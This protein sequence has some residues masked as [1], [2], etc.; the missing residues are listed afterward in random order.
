MS[1]KLV[2]IAVLISVGVSAAFGQPGQATAFATV[3][4]QLKSEDPELRRG[5][6]R[7]LGDS[8]YPEAIG[9]I[10]TLLRDPLADIQIET[11]NT[12]L[13]FFV[14]EP[15]KARRYVGIVELRNTRLAEAAFDLGP[16]AVIPQRVP[17]DLT[18]NLAV[19]M[20]DQSDRTRREAVY[21]LGVMGRPPVDSRTADAV[22]RTLKDPE[23]GVRRA[24]ARVA[25]AL[26]IRQAGDALIEA[27]NDRNEGV[28]MA[29]MRAVGDLREWRA[30]QALADLF[31]YYGRG[32]LAEAA[33]DGLARI[34][35]VSS[36]ELFR[37]RLTDPTPLIRRYAV[38]GLA[39]S[40][41]QA[42]AAAVATRLA[43]ETDEGVRVALAFASIAGGGSGAETLVRALDE[44]ARHEQ[45]MDYFVDL[46]SRAIPGLRTALQQPS[47]VVRQRAA[48]VL[49]FIEGDEALS[50]VESAQ[51]DPDVD[52]AR[53]A[54]RATARIRQR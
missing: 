42:A 12:L 46:G 38:E 51:R 24:A 35:H 22:I 49:G 10:S 8:G 50:L 36:Q 25:G 19:A 4:A 44:N 3:V 14:V 13:Q 18:Q 1:R 7:A 32:A 41:N 33:F 17:E 40:G 9:P 47:G 20:A 23:T 39:R 26:R 45:A 53:A 28:R 52:V 29:A 37:E 5:A 2:L 48:V 27:M 15:L 43:G 54:E 31:D 34:A 30:L 11:I 16:Y 21:A 6:L